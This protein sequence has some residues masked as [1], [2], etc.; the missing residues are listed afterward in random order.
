MEI[1]EFLEIMKNAERW[2]WLERN[3]TLGFNGAPGW[4]ATLSF[5][6]ASPYVNTL[7]QIVDAGMKI[8][9]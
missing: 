9:K 4:Q 6:A 1:E 7:A 2:K 5:P 8:L 3:S